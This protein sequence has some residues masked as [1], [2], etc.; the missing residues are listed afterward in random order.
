MVKV[1]GTKTADFTAD[2]FIL[3]TDTLG[4][5]I[6]NEHQELVDIRTWTKR[7]RYKNGTFL[8]GKGYNEYCSW[9]DFNPIAKEDKNYYLW[10]FEKL[11]L[12]GD[13]K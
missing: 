9:S 5:A 8:Y 13:K 1:S 6:E 7:V 3:I 12:N 2:G 10:V 4:N 11:I